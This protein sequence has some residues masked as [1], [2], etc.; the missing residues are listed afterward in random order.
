[1]NQNYYRSEKNVFGKRQTYAENF[2][3]YHPLL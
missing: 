2:T 3:I 1:M